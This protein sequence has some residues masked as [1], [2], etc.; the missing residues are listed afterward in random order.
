LL[1]E[2]LDRDDVRVGQCRRRLRFLE[3]ACLEAGVGGEVGVH[4]LDRDRPPEV[5]VRAAIDLAH[6]AGPKEFF[7]AVVADGLPDC[8]NGHGVTS[9]R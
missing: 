7:E 8:G 3:E 4:Q 9:K 5:D 1:A 2:I 6:P